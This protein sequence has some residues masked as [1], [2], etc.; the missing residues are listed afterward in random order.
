MKSLNSY[1]AIQAWL[2][3]FPVGCHLTIT[4]TLAVTVLAGRSPAPERR[5][6]IAHTRD[7]A[8][9]YDGAQ[10][11]L[12]ALLYARRAV[13]PLVG[14]QAIPRHMVVFEGRPAGE[15]ADDMLRRADDGV[16]FMRL[17]PTPHPQDSHAR[18]ILAI[19]RSRRPIGVTFTEV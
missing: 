17:I 5:T 15:V 9:A 12:L 2:F 3:T 1:K 8:R 19:Y 4:P 16:C 6:F 14:A 7:G 13:L 18:N 11:A 10:R